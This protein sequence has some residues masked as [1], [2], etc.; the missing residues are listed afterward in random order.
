MPIRIYGTNNEEGLYDVIHVGW[1]EWDSWNLHNMERPNDSSSIYLRDPVAYVDY[2]A[3]CG[4]MCII[5][6]M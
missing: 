3:E 2:M 1:W 4:I 6:P 5:Y